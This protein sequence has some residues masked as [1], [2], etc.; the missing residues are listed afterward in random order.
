[1]E[2]SLFIKIPE[3]NKNKKT[4]LKDFECSFILPSIISIIGPNGAGK[5]TLLSC[6]LDPKEY[7]DLIFK[8]CSTDLTKVSRL[9]YGKIVGFLG[10]SDY[11]Q[12][13]ILVSDFIKNSGY[14][15]TLED[16]QILKELGFWGLRVTIN[17]KVSELSLG[18]FQ[19]LLLL[20]TFIQ[21]SKLYILDEPD[22]HLDPK[23]KKLL[24]KKIKSLKELGKTILFSTHDLDFSLNVSEYFI[25]IKSGQREFLCDYE[26]LLKCK[27]LDSLFETEFIYC[28]LDNRTHVFN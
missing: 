25:G 4:I 6:L 18:Q 11:S 2:N 23:G 5:T 28:K 21:D 19:R 20:T 12:P 1:M 26:T 15:S 3:V 9:E 8:F 10:S 22:R 7:L 27:F 17:Q 14:I 13:E 24:V 16:S